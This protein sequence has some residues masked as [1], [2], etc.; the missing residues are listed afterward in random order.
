MFS[1]TNHYLQSK[2]FKSRIAAGLPSIEIKSSRLSFNY[3]S[4][5][6]A[7]LTGIEPSVLKDPRLIFL[8]AQFYNNTSDGRTFALTY[9]S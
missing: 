8:I 7:S 1:S 6:F 3:D 5:V 9:F 4:V 2:E